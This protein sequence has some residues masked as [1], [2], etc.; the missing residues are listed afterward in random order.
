MP[1]I[2]CRKLKAYHQSQGMQHQ[3][4]VYTITYS[5][6]ALTA[7]MCLFLGDAVLG[8]SSGDRQEERWHRQGA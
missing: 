3:R 8:R 6:T 4:Y 5:Y 7:Y 1:K 2:L